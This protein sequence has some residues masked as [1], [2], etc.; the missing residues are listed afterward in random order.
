MSKGM[1]LV[2]SRFLIVVIASLLILAAGTVGFAAIEHLSIED[3]AYFTVVTVTTVGYGDIHPS[4]HLGKLLSIGLIVVGVGTFS[5]VM[6]NTAEIIFEHRERGRR[7]ERAS[8]LVGVFYSEIGNDLIRLLLSADPDVEHLCRDAIVSENWT[9][10]EFASLRSRIERHEYSID[11]A[12][13]PFAEMRDTLSRKTDMLLRFYE[14]PTL[15]EEDSFTGLLRAT[16]HLREELVLRQTLDSPASDLGHLAR[17]AR[18]VY[19]LLS[20]NW[21]Q[22]TYRLRRTYPYLF[23]LAVRTNP[24]DANCS[25]VVKQPE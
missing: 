23:S 4:T 18:R 25:P 2:F 24:F 7:R 6:V 3:A 11:Y 17:D 20:E 15:I 9:E 8:A 21:L 10:A 1:K 13:A 22:Y 14:N 12:K 19:A 16:L 5:G